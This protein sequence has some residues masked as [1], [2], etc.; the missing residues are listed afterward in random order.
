[1]LHTGCMGLLCLDNGSNVISDRQDVLYSP[2]I[3]FGQ[4]EQPS[5]PQSASSLRP[6]ATWAGKPTKQYSQYDAAGHRRIDSSLVSLRLV[7]R[8]LTM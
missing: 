2:E 8:L 4:L 6:S 5:H 3:V 1:M 7:C